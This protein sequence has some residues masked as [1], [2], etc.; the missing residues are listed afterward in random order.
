MKDNGFG[1]LGADAGH[2]RQHFELL[3]RDGGAELIGRG[4]A[5]HRQRR[6]RAD[7]AHAEQQ[8]E[9]V[10]FILGRKAVQRPIV[11][12]NVQVSG[13]IERASDRRCVARGRRNVDAQPNV[14]DVDDEIV[15]SDRFNGAVQVSDHRLRIQNVECRIENSAVR[16]EKVASPLSLLTSDSYLL[17]SHKVVIR[18]ECK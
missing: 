7:A 15:F 14:A 8:F 13:E 12:T 3:V 16:I 4:G 11:F 5:Q 9:H 17:Y 1:R 18:A 2:P 10:Q 6:P